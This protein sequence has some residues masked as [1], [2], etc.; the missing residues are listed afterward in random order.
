MITETTQHPV[1]AAIRRW[2]GQGHTI[3]LVP[4]MGNLH[5]GHGQLVE[6]AREYAERVVVSIFV[7]PMQFDRP[8][9][10]AAYPRTLEQDQVLLQQHRVDLLFAPQAEALYPQGIAAT[11]YVEVPELSGMLC[12]ASRPGH[13]RG[14]A[15]MVMKLFNIVQPDVAVFGHKDYQQLLII[16]RMVQ[17]LDMPISIVGAPTVREADGLAMSSRN[18][19]LTSPER[20]RASILYQGLREV[21]DAIW[22]GERDFARLEATACTELEAAGFKPDYVAVRRAQDLRP[23]GA[24]VSKI[25]AVS[26]ALALQEVNNELI[27]LG[28]AWLGRARL[29]DNVPVAPTR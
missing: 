19:Y 2:R 7:N 23:P 1:R 21:A 9:D 20:T 14:V 18:G 13:F 29:I 12:G 16:K 28:A 26:K 6:V 4:T 25:P 17:D 5:A 8:D 11:T 24:G 15:T 22:A 3:A 27:V 10:L